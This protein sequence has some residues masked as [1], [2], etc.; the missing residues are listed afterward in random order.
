MEIVF[1]PPAKDVVEFKKTMGHIKTFV[2]NVEA[3][4]TNMTKR[5]HDPWG[6]G[7]SVGPLEYPPAVNARQAAHNWKGSVQVNVGIDAREYHSLLKWYAASSYATATR[8]RATVP[9]PLANA[10]EQLFKEAQTH[11]VTAVDVGRTVTG[12]VKKGI[13][14]AGVALT[15]KELADAGNLRGLRGWL[16]HIA[17]YLVRGTANFGGAAGTIKNLAP[18]LLKSPPEIVSDYGLPAE[19]IKI[20][21][22]QQQAILDEI[23][24]RVGR[25]GDVGQPANAI[26][27]WPTRKTMLDTIV[28]LQGKAVPLTTGAIMNPTSVGPRR[29]GNAAVKAIKDVPG[30][31]KGEERGGIVPEFRMIPGYFEG[32]AAWKTLGL[33][34][35]KAAIKRNRRSGIST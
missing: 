5:A 1:D 30:A 8:A 11:I 7:V 22:A 20:F 2:Q 23:N 16:T 9:A 27:V 29:T 34:F 15:K 25:P 12:L 19:E 21:N 31:A 17:F 6:T 4:T 26:K 33:D 10:A 14:P 18:V 32:P 28:D 24:G 35:L 3:L 13:P